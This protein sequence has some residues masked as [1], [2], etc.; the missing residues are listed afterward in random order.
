MRPSV[1][2]TVPRFSRRFDAATSCSPYIS[3]SRT[4]SSRM[5]DSFADSVRSLGRGDMAHQSYID[6]RLMSSRSRT[7]R[8]GLLVEVVSLDRALHQNDG[9]AGTRNRH[10]GCFPAVR[11][12]AVQ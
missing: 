3:W 8:S 11:T 6:V 4:S 1:T 10:A 2:Y 12:G 7:L 5:S 9:V